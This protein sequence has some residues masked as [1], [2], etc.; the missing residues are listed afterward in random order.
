MSDKQLAEVS[1][2]HSEPIPWRIIDPGL[3]LEGR[4]FAKN[5]LCYAYRQ[6]VIGNFQMGQF[7]ISRM[8]TFKCPMCGNSVQTEKFGLNRCR[9][10]IMNTNKWSIVNDV[11]QMYDL[12]QLPINI[13]I[14]SLKKDNNSTEN[15]TICLLSMEKKNICSILPCKHIFHTECIHSWIDA[16]EETSLQCPICRRPIFE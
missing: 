12:N 8:S 5:G 1:F 16:E 3:C 6:M 14:R 2:S 7:T 9:W 4:C 15:C 10:R 11:Y 13:E